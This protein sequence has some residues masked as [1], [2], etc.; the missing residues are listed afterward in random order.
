MKRNFHDFNT[1]LLHS[2]GDRDPVTGALSTPIYQVSTFHQDPENPSKYEYS[3]SANP[4]RDVLEEQIAQLEK[5]AKGFAFSSGL[6]ALTTVLFLFKPG[7]HLIVAREIY[8]GSHRLFTQVFNQWQLEIDFVDISDLISVENA[9]KKNTKAICFEILSNPFLE[10]ADL[11]SLIKICQ[12]N[13]LLSIID[14]TFLPPCYCRPLELGADIVLHSA[15]KYLN[16]HS[17]VIAGVAAV[18][19]E[20]LAHRLGFMQNALGAVLGPQDC[21]L[22]LRG[23]KTLGVRLER[24]AESAQKIATWLSEQP[25]V[26]KTYYPGLPGFPGKEIL[27][28]ISTGYGSIVTFEVKTREIKESLM[29]KLSLAAIAVSLG[30]VESIL[31]HPATMSHS[32]M[33]SDV[34]KE[35]GI[36]DNLFRLSV[37]LENPLDLIQDFREAINLA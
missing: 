26:V 18:R 14:N 29:Q 7:D 13:N 16:G 21:W 30:A 19:D 33:P 32:G 35:L 34:K 15:T 31:T 36:S 3:R 5:G 27:D 28:S 1:L 37:G 25:W 20:N 24:Q 2:A 9:I 17:D 23:I 4:T 11:K 22:L 6:A 8:G 10:I 12:N